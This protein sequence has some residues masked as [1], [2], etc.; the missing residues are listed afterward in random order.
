MHF[1]ARA[2]AA[3]K[4]LF[5]IIKSESQ[6]HHLC[7]FSRLLYGPSLSFFPHTQASGPANVAK[8]SLRKT[9]MGIRKKRRRNRRRRR[10]LV[11]LR[12][13]FLH[14]TA[15]ICFIHLRRRKSLLYLR[16]KKDRGGV[17]IG[18]T[19]ETR[20]NLRKKKCSSLSAAAVSRRGGKEINGSSKMKE[21]S[22]FPCTDVFNVLLWQTLQ[23]IKCSF[24]EYLSELGVS[25]SPE[26]WGVERNAFRGSGLA[27]D[28]WLGWSRTGQGTQPTSWIIRST[29]E[30]PFKLHFL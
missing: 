29:F 4:A 10:S 9:R 14:Y 26:A 17:G 19:K 6:F 28:T 18:R 13:L 27:V 12:S 25:F 16:V 15:S 3:K 7:L 1:Q 23:F 11:L 22:Q 5:C 24:D 8:F 21:K 2:A 30:H 20:G